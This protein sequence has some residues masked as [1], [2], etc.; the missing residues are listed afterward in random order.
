MLAFFGLRPEDKSDIILEPIF[1]LMYYGG[2]T[3]KEAYNMPVSYK[4]W[5]IQRISR[6]LSRT[7][8][9]G[10]TQSRA[11]HDNTPDTRALLGNA[12]TETPSRLR[13]FT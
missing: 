13:R 9:Q 2:F 7:S 8:E 11:L 6:E 3:Y 10:H 12:R 1:L 4:N 5:F